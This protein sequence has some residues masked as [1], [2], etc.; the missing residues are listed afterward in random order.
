MI[1]FHYTTALILMLALNACAPAPTNFSFVKPDSDEP[2]LGFPYEDP[3]QAVFI[4]CFAL[5]PWDNPLPLQSSNMLQ[6]LAGPDTECQGEK[7]VGIDIYPVPNSQIRHFP[8]PSNTQMALVRIVALTD[9]IVE[10]I[11]TGRTGATTTSYIVVLK[12]NQFWHVS[13]SFEPHSNDTKIQVQN[14]VVE[15][16]QKVKKGDL[17]GS[18]VVT[19]NTEVEPSL[20]FSFFYLSPE[21]DLDQLMTQLTNDIHSVHVSDG[22][23]VQKVG[24]PWDGKELDIP[25]TFF[26]PYE[27]SSDSAKRIY[28][29]LPKLDVNGNKCSSMCAYGS[30]FGNCGKRHFELTE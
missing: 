14:L 20:H 21:Q 5:C 8:L 11:V 2:G 27:F 28:D 3:G 15:E 10:R 18:L 6:N 1:R 23:D 12:L 9:G 19:K 30:R 7:H 17:I 26:C 25:T 4:H 16:T 29:R 22:S 13:Y 24:W